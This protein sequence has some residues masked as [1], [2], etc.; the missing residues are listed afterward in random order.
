VSKNV[1]KKV[2]EDSKYEWE[3]GLIEALKDGMCQDLVELEI[4]VHM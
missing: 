1:R 3:D 4:H 2:L